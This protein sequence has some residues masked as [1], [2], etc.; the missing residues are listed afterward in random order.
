MNDGVRAAA[1]AVAKRLG[2]LKP[3]VAIVLG[4]G[5]A[6][7]ADAVADPVRMPYK[8]IPGFPVPLTRA[9]G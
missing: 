5:L 8:A 6:G 9:Q 7:V 4:S 1:D 2:T 3:R